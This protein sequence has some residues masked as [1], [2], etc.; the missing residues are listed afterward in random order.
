MRPHFIS[1]WWKTQLESMDTAPFCHG[2]PGME[3]TC[4]SSGCGMTRGFRDFLRGRWVTR[5]ARESITRGRKCLCKIISRPP[6]SETHGT[7][8]ESLQ[9]LMSTKIS[10]EHRSTRILPRPHIR[11]TQACPRCRTRLKRPPG[12][13]A[14]RPEL[15]TLSNPTHRTATLPVR[16]SMRSD[17]IATPIAPAHPGEGAFRYVLL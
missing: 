7:R 12:I 16:P 9:R 15:I 1:R 5:E 10:V 4:G 17:P 13:R 14:T 8:C 11:A 3:I 6:N 2:I